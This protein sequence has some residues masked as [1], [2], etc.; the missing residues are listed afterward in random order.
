MAG[1]LDSSTDQGL[2]SRSINHM[3]QGI[4]KINEG[5]EFQVGSQ[6]LHPISTM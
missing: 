1:D 2:I 5:S 4:S 3:A 6:K